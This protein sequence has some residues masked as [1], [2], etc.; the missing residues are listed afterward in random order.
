M[1]D[2]KFNWSAEDGEDLMMLAYD[3]ETAPLIEWLE[4][5][6]L[7]RLDMHALMEFTGRMIYKT[8]PLALT[9]GVTLD[10]DEFWGLRI[11]EASST[12][13]DAARMITASLNADWDNLTAL[14]NASLT[15]PEEYHAGVFVH[16]FAAWGDGLHAIT[17][18]K[19]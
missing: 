2:R 1:S 6:V 16:L 9:K 12:S 7:N 3:R 5:H 10:A 4:S 19:R 8:F 15:Q 18:A 17:E 14:I 11:G 13:A